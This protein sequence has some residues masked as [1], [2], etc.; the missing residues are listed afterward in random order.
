[1]MDR[2][3][4]RAFGVAALR[5]EARRAAHWARARSWGRGKASRLSPASCFELRASS[6]VRALLGE[7]IRLLG[8]LPALAAQGV[9]E[10][11]QV[12][13]LLR[14]QVQRSDPRVQPAVRGAVG[15]GARATP[16]ILLDH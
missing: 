10:F 8:V 3:L 4:S 16:I 5:L 12:L 6:S 11:H 7:L 1:M 9:K 13:L 14:R 15:E 2:L